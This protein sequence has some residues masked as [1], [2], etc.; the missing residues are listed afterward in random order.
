[1]ATTIDKAELAQRINSLE[2]LD[3]ETKSQLLELLHE[4]KRYGLVWEDKPEAAEERLQ[5]E[6]PILR[7]V[8]ERAII[9]DDPVAPNHILIEGDNLEALT[10][11]SYTHEGKIDVIYIDPPYNTGNKDFVYNDSYVDTEDQ[12]RHSKWLSFMAKRLK[13]AKRLLSDKGVIFISIDDNEQAQLKLLCDEVFGEDNFISLLTIETGEVFGTKASHVDK[14][15]VKVKD[16][17]LAYSKNIF[18]VLKQP[19][20]DLAREPFDTH[21]SRIVL[22]DMTSYGLMDYLAMNTKIKDL[23]DKSGILFK[24]DNISI[25]MK[26]NSDFRNYIFNEIAPYAYAD[27]PYNT[28]IPESILSNKNA[29][30]LFLFDNK[31]CFRTKVG[32]VRMLI[33]FSD[34]L[35]VSDDYSREYGR[36]SLRGD[37]WKGFHTDMRN[38]DDE[39]GVSFKNGKKPVRLIS[40]LL[41][42]TNLKSAYVLDFFAGSGTTL[43]ATMQMNA[44]DGGHRHCILVTN[45]ENNICEEVTYERNKR[46]I[47]GYT[48]PKGEQVEGLHANTL[49]YFKTDYV[50]RESSATAK[51]ELMYAAT[52]MLC[53]KNNIYTEQPMFGSRKF[54]K[55][56]CRYFQDGERGMLVIYNPDAIEV[57]AEELKKMQ[58]EQPILVYVFSLNDYAMDADFEDVSEKVSLCALPAAILNA[59]RKVLPKK[60]RKEESL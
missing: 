25:L 30:E 56:V 50:A 9:S 16:Y 36:C 45:N 58:I 51:R 10:T 4:R 55:D 41:K 37:L 54:R 46:V 8:K 11:L 40:Q 31:I 1:M 12:F 20:Y 48:T 2:G 53:I 21:Y 42:W 33:K 15:F 59:Y 43:H 52:D 28:A 57:I 26:I 47:N 60:Q 13:I 38:I 7:E 18:P 23:F 29:G 17:V 39:G 49:R 44:E 32:T 5:N 35:R 19:L 3:N 22:D 27:Q 6:L 24:K 34:S 14:T